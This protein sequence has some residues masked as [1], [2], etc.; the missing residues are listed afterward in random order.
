MP[1]VRFQSTRPRGARLKQSM[2]V[3]VKYMFQSTRPRGARHEFVNGFVQYLQVSIHAPAWGA[4]RRRR[5]PAASWSTFQSTRPRGARLYNGV[6]YRGT[7]RFN[8][9][10]RVG[11]DNLTTG[12]SACKIGFNPRARV[13]RDLQ[14]LFRQTF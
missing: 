4:T 12:A 3:F 1:E 14:L 11:R 9:R 10:A 13:G 5:Q 6:R 2:L 7:M 8:P